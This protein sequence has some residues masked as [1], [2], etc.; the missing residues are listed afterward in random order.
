MKIIGVWLI[1]VGMVA[2]SCNKNSLDETSSLAVTETI[3]ACPITPIQPDFWEKVGPVAGE[4][5]VW[6]SSNGQSS[7]SQLGPKVLFPDSLDLTSPE[8]RLTKRLIFVDDQTEGDLL[9]T[10]RRIDGDGDVYFNDGDEDKI[11]RVDDTT[12]QLSTVFPDTLL[13]PSAH[14]STHFP[15]PEDKSHH[16]M[17]LIFTDPGCYELTATL[18]EYIV[19]V[20]IELTPD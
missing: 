17:G 4:F 18:N 13:I 5:P 8:G 10:G 16:G 14:I 2:V 6:I 15:T 3:S 12:L 7:F 19:H 11:V 20:T 9:I 1:I